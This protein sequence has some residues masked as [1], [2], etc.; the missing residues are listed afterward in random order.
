MSKVHFE[1]PKVRKMTIYFKLLKVSKMTSLEIYISPITEKLEID[2]SFRLQV[3][4]IQKVLLGTPHQQVV[5]LLSHDHVT[6]TNLFISS[7]ARAT[8]IK[9]GQYKQLLDISP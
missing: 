5:T 4:L 9:F 1:L 6:L 2:V 8:V 3:S 7:Y